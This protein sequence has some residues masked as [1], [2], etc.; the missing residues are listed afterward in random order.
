[1][2]I[3]RLSISVFLLTSLLLA[4]IQVATAGDIPTVKP[5]KG[6]VVHN[7]NKSYQALVDAVKTAAKHSELGVVTE[8]G[9]TRAAAKRGIKIPGNRVI[10]L[11][12]NKYAVRILKDST[13][14]MIEAPI[15]MYVTEA[16]DGTATLSY[17][18]PS[19]VYQP[20]MEEGGD[21]LKQAAAA[22]DDDFA[23]IA[24][25]ALKKP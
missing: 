15:R 25:A 1:M 24:T 2:T 3:Q 9:P 14:A 19:Y 4:G 21:D 20:Y 18:R 13:A 5:R 7:S 8:A 12:N 10:G 11:F 6:W 17:K 23:K 16:P 22:L